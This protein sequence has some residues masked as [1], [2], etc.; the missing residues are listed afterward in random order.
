MN[1]EFLDQGSIEMGTGYKTTELLFEEMPSVRHSP[2]G[3]R[4]QSGEFVIVGQARSSG[5]RYFKAYYLHKD[6]FWRGSPWLNGYFDPK[7]AEETLAK[8]HAE[9]LICK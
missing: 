7:E 8:V 2:S 1:V 9:I 5:T 6:M 3:I 4:R